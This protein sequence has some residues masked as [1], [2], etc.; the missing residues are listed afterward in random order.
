MLASNGG[1]GI[2]L[3]ILAVLV[4]VTLVLGGG[5]PKTGLPAIKG[6]VLAREVDTLAVA[7]AA[8]LRESARALRQLG[9]DRGILRDPIGQGIFA[10]L[11]DSTSC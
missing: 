1:R 7:V 9:G 3:E 6:L 8:A 4:A 2:I 5:D 11:D 10:I